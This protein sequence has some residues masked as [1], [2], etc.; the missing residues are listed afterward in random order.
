MALEVRPYTAVIVTRK[1]PGNHPSC[2]GGKSCDDLQGNRMQPSQRRAA[3]ASPPQ[4]LAAAIEGKPT[5][6]SDS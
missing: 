6:I 2:S 3:S 1:R 5:T 4:L